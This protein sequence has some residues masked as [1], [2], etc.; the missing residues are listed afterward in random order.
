MTDANPL[1]GVSFHAVGGLAAASFYLPYRGVK[2]WPWE[3]YW[4]VGGV[5]SWLIAPIVGAMLLTPHVIETLRDTPTTA[6][7]WTFLFGALWGVGGLTFGLSMRYLGIALGYAV[8]LGLCALFGTI[9]PPIFDGSIV[10]LVKSAGGLTVLG[11]L[12]VCLAGIAVSGMAGASKQREL[13][14]EQKK[15]TVAE[16]NFPKGMAVAVFCGLMSACMS[17]AFVAGKPINKSALDHGT[18]PLWQGLPVLVVAL[19]G[20]LATNLVWC[21]ILNLKNHTGGTY[22]AAESRDGRVPLGLNYLLCAAA[23][24]LWYLQFFFYSMGDTKMGKYQFSGWSLHMASI[25]IFSTLWG[26]ALAEWRGTS[27]RTH[28]LIGIGLGLLIASMCVI[29][30]GN[31]IAPAK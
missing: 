30:W 23:G 28:T 10:N 2:R 20:G 16:F 21:V 11:G 18:D 9:V 26:V 1:L 27:R 4:I 7:L 22:I 17:F 24:I 14:D 13:S 31:Y 25:I 19:L 5:F 12:G 3:T 6:L 15:S 29:G 8:A